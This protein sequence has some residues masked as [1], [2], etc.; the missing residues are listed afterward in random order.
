MQS[1]YLGILRQKVESGD[2]KAELVI[3]IEPA[4]LR[5]DAHQVISRHI[6]SHSEQFLT[7]SRTRKEKGNLI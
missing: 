6:Y 2:M 5:S 4:K 3:L 1:A 7:M